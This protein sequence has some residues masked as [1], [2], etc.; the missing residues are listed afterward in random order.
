MTDHLTTAT[1][2]ADPVV[3]AINITRDFRATPAQ[4]IRAHID[5]EL[6]AKWNGPD[7][8]ANEIVEW[9]ARSGGSWRYIHRRGDEDRDAGRQQR[10]PAAGGGV[11]DQLAGIGGAEPAAGRGDFAPRRAHPRADLPPMPLLRKGAGLVCVCRL[12]GF[13]S[14]V[15]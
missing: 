12:L 11:E 9:D 10:R 8:L 5:P 13:Y 14:G 15:E 7:D 6:F 1:I 3:P 4:V 2:E